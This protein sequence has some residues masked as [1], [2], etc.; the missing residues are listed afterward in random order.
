VKEVHDTNLSNEHFSICVAGETGTI[1][2]L[3]VKKTNKDLIQEKGLSRN[4]L[5]C[6]PLK[7]NECHY[8]EGM[9]QCPSSILLE[10]NTIYVKFVDIVSNGIT[11]PI[12]V[13]YSI[14]LDQDTIRMK[15][16]LEN[17]SDKPI[18]EFWFPRL[19]GIKF[20]KKTE[21]AVVNYTKTDEVD[22]KNSYPGGRPLGSPAAEW[23]KKYPLEMDMPWWDI[24]DKNSNTGIYLG[25]HDKI[26]RVSHWHTYLYPTRASAE[27]AW[28]TEE[29]ALGEKTG[30]VFSHVRYPYIS[31]GETLDSG[32]F[33]IHCHD[34]DWH[35]G[36]KIY[37]K[38]FLENFNIDKSNS[39]LRKKTSW[40]SSILFEPEDKIN[41]DYKT[42]AQWT[43]DAQAYGIDCVEAIGWDKG[44]LERY[45]P[46]YEPEE[47]LGGVSGFKEMVNSI[48]S[49]NSHLLA[50][51]NYNI[52]DWASDEY[53]DKYKKLALKDGFGKIPYLMS[54]GESTLTARTDLSVRKHVLASASTEFKKI[55]I[56]YFTA[57]ADAGVDGVQIDKLV[58]NGTLDFNPLCRSKPDVSLFED[59]YQDLL[60][61]LEA[62][63]KINPKFLYAAETHVDRH[64]PIVDVFYRMRYHAPIRYVFPEI[65]GCRHISS[66]FDYNSVN[67]AVLEGLVLCVEP[68]SYQT[69]LSS[70]L[71]R[72]LAEYIK[73][74]ERIRKELLDVIFLGKYFDMD[75][76]TI[77]QV[78]CGAKKQQAKSSEKVA[79]P[80][81]FMELGNKQTSNTQAISGDLEYRVFGHNNS[82]QKAIIVINTGDDN[83]D[84]TWRFDDDIEE[85]LLYQPFKNKEIVNCKSIN[86]INANNI[87]ILLSK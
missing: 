56:K 20:P 45:Y 36:S 10:N 13:S 2:S 24:Y 76:A 43:K 4:F 39:W 33:I 64:I 1:K 29:E 75:N 79:I 77:K 35:N 14:K 52:L 9:E 71:Y 47:I 67:K 16:T 60:E 48:S 18:T 38:W 8:I 11:Y 69:T 25:Y 34:D 42:F 66:P 84:Y 59:T 32:E 83:I 80:G 61:I 27:R 19:G 81:E 23:K 40:Y 26:F 62:C 3:I 87:Q 82:K 65:T 78:S 37:R 55:I 22:F 46:E 57:L 7:H 58:A 30:I 63:K 68:D 15:S 72:K 41:A 31:N 54:W 6:L 28:L 70:P 53:K 85:C 5:I 12:N 51:V 21:S 50:F 86:T 49:C 44:G 74:I 17:K 73:E